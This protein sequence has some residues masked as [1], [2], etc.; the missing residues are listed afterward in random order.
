GAVQLALTDSDLPITQSGSYLIRCEAACAGSI[1]VDPGL[2]VSLTLQGVQTTGALSAGAGT[3]LA[4]ALEGASRMDAGI[5]LSDGA[6]L[7]VSGAG[8]LLAGKVDAAASAA[9]AVAPSTNLSLGSGALGGSA[10]QPTLMIVTDNQELP[11]RQTAITMKIG[12]GQPFDTTT[13]ANGHVTLWAAQAITGQDVVVLSQ[14]ETYAAIV[15]GGSG[16]P[17]A[18]PE[19]TNVKVKDATLS[20]DVKNAQTTGVQYYVGKAIHEMGDRF[21]EGALRV[22]AEAGKT[23]VTLSGLQKGDVV[24]YRV[25]AAREAGA[26]LTAQTQSAFQFSPQYSFLYKEPFSLK[27]QKKPY[28]G[29]PFKFKKDQIPSTA[30]I[31]WY[32]D[33]KKLSSAPT[34]VGKYVAHVEIPSSDSDYLSGDVAVSIV[35]RHVLVYPLE[36]SKREGEPDPDVFEFYYDY[37]DDSSLTDNGEGVLP[38]DE[39][40]GWLTRKPG[41]KHGNY[42]YYGNRLIA[43]D[44]YD[45]E[46]D[47]YS[48]LFFIDWGPKHY[49]KVDPLSIINPIHQVLEFSTGEQL[50]M[51]QKTADKLSISGVGY[52]SLVT[53]T[54]DRKARPFTPS[55]RLKHGYDEAML[56]VQAEAEINKDGGYETDM[57]GKIVWRGRTL[58]LTLSQLRHFKAQHITRIGFRLDNM[59]CLLDL[60]DLT[61]EKAT[62]LRKD[63]DLSLQGARY[64]IT[65][66]PMQT[67]DD[68]DGMSDNVKRAWTLGMP[69]TAVSVELRSGGEAIDLT[70]ALGS[71]R[72]LYDASSLLSEQAAASPEISEVVIG[73]KQSEPEAD[74]TVDTMEL[75]AELA[76]KQ[77]ASIGCELW[78]YDGKGALD[79]SLVVPYTASES[80]AMPFTAVMQTQPYLIAKSDGNGLY[81]LSLQ[82]AR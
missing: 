67:L 68:L 42:P 46:V 9:I 7:S 31:T 49:I 48:P 47:R 37:Y 30:T 74:V 36:Y 53:D 18:L 20:Y 40:T 10:L 35:K 21:E 75:V 81:G 77:L 71:L 43:P 57:D 59:M 61:G 45:V 52:G 28:D 58:T 72:L 69:M 2:D 34:D 3:K 8:A 23:S 73:R 38:G 24:T 25:F 15:S 29:A 54:L 50:D 26:S 80:Q 44:Y 17:D 1:L 65:L 33:G 14:T 76:Q 4:L 22:A 6:A 5:A 51:I 41:E 11:M 66:Q 78:R 39:I 62:L 60:A 12:G 27:E 63:S 64:V 70:P 82:W 19:I 55:L 32:Q 13:D 56:I 79:S 16:A